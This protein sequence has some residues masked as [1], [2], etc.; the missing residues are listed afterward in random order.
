MLAC[1]VNI[2]EGR[3][4]AVVDEVA[5]VTTSAL[6]DLH[7]D[8]DHNRSVLTLGGS[9]AF[10]A[11]CALARAATTRLDLRRHHGVH[12]RLGVLDVVPFVPI[13]E[14]LGDDMDLI[15]AIAARDAFAGYAASELGLACFLYGPERSLPEIR[16]RAFVDLEPDF[17]PA[18]RND[19]LGAVCVGARAPLIAYNVVLRDNDFAL[20]QTIARSLR[21]PW[22]RA[23]AFSLGERV[24]VSSNLV[25]PWHFGPAEFYDAVA[26]RA[27]VHAAELVG[28]LPAEVLAGIEPGRY[29]ELDVSREQTI[30]FRLSRLGGS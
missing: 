25:A 14:P 22:V 24:Q 19:R 9:D 6:L 11:A 27:P 15:E 16:R 28:L 20:A 18:A 5:S 3:D 21:S 23:L 26:A 17:G 7:S 2:S 13:G 1:V 10:D 29:E 4:L 30:E 8:P 12:P